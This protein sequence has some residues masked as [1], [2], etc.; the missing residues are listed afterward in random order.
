MA[1]AP[2]TADR[3]ARNWAERLGC[4]PDAFQEPGVTIADPGA[5]ESVRLFRRADSLVVAAPTRVRDALAGSRALLRDVDPPATAVVERAVAVVGE[6]VEATHGPYVLGYVDEPSFSPAESDARLLVGAE[7][8]AF[9]RLR[10]RV[11]PDEWARASP[12]FRPGRTAG[13]FVDEDLV[14]VST[15]THAPFPDV[16]VVV[17][18]E[19]R[20][21]GHGRA[22]V[23]KITTTAFDA[24]PT[25]IVR[26]RTRET[27][28]GSV[29]I[30]ESLG[31]EYWATS[32][33]HVLAG[34]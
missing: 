1:L 23:S 27:T 26:Y 4:S 14:A 32:A 29:A 9:E 22:V 15:L 21:Q 34:E 12:V 18:P 2:A 10:Q 20:G 7:E 17:A 13:L 28:P 33:V 24:D 5:S 30:A 25:V 19:A 3:I 11:P 8:P 16:G 31:Y 6:T